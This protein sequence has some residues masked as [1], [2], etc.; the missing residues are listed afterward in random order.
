MSQ[1]EDPI[2]P[3]VTSLLKELGEDPG[4]NGLARTPVRSVGTPMR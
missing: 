4:R 3:L 2:E 1:L